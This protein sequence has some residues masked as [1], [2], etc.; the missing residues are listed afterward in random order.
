MYSKG[1]CTHFDDVNNQ[2][3]VN[4]KYNYKIIIP[5]NFN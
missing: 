4:K 5:K 3:E 1:P 2:I